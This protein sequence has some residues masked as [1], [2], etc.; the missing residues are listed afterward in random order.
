MQ[1]KHNKS[2][3][4]GKKLEYR[5]KKKQLDER[6]KGVL[7]KRKESWV[8][9]CCGESSRDH[10]CSKVK[11]GYGKQYYKNG[12][13][14]YDGNWKNHKHHGQ[15]KYYD[16]NG[17]MTYNGNWKDSKY[18]GHGKYYDQNGQMRYDGDWK[19]DN[20]EG[21]GKYYEQNGHMQYE[22]NWKDNYPY[23]QGVFYHDN[24]C[25]N[26][27]PW[28]FDIFS[29]CKPTNANQREYHLNGKQ[30]TTKCKYDKDKNIKGL[31][32]SF[33]PD[34]SIYTIQ[35]GD[36]PTI[37][38]QELQTRYSQGIERLERE[39]EEKRALQEMEFLQEAQDRL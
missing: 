27:V 37:T 31:S 22:G 5:S 11:N 12:N 18:Y 4:K 20:R 8:L 32:T 7:R 14:Q 39:L 25:C 9:S 10:H 35:N 36:S 17:Q 6:D 15:G 3:Y 23:G 13:L 24:E 21:Q 38:L 33:N 28:I 16:E 29:E 2:A 34:G 1:K 30:I 19:D 26:N